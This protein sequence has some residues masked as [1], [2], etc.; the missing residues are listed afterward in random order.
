MLDF[1]NIHFE[2]NNRI[3]LND[4]SMRLQVGE[5]VSLLGPSGC[6]KTTLLKLASGI[7]KIQKGEIKLNNQTI[8]SRD[9]HLSPDKRGIGYVFQDCALFP[10]LTISQNI[11]FGMDKKEEQLQ[12]KKIQQLMDE[13][14]LSNFSDKYPHELSGGQQQQV[15][16]IRAMAS[17]PQ[18]ILLDEPYS[19][20]DSRLKEKIRDQMLHILRENNISALL[21]THDPEEAMFMSD[22][23]GVLNNGFIEQFGS[24]IDLYLR[25]KS[26]FIAEFFGEINVFGGIVEEGLVNTVLGTFSCPKKFNKSK[27]KIVIRNEAIMLYSDKKNISKNTNKNKYIISPYIGCVMEARLLAGSTLVHLSIKVGGDFNVIQSEI[28]CYDLSKWTND[29]LYLEPT[30]KKM[31]ELI[32]VGFIDSF[33]LLH[34]NLKEFSFWDYQAGAWQKDNGIRIDFFLISP[35]IVDRLLNAGID[36]KPRG[37]EKPSDHTPIWIEVE[38]I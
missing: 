28:D 14:N 21:V 33:R 27:V 8:S 38:N 17:D 30:R 10:H 31:K 4:F 36:K 12:T 6:G 18:I 3:I 15:A 32:N 1:L 19:N 23:I 29:A 34:P 5:V 24:P 22:K 25:P 37:K 16:L 11:F 9:T 20:L 26:A 7:E 13:V 2:Y 35:E